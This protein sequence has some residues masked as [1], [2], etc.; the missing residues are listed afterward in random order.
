MDGFFNEDKSYLFTATNSTSIT[1]TSADQALVSFRLSPSVDYGIIGRL[2]ERSLVNH[3][4]LKPQQ[5]G[6]L[7][8][9]PLQ[10]NVRVNCE[11]QTVFRNLSA[12]KFVANGSI[13][14]Y[15]DHTEDSSFEVQGTGGDLIASFLI[16]PE[17]EIG[18]GLFT[19]QSF[20]IGIVRELTN[21]IL[22]GDFPYP[23]GPDVVTVSVKTLSH[24]D[25]NYTAICQG[26]VSWTEDQ[27]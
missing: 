22:G 13:A 7:T 18:D 21:S 16:T 8:N 10:V 20:D 5:V 2:G 9:N 26:K 6:I 25:G 17:A 15:F 24:L 3:S 4:T 19:S 1:A 12:W 23:D 11:P 27:G 14:Q